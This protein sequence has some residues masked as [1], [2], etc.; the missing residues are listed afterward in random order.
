MF[1]HSIDMKQYHK[2]LVLADQSVENT[3]SKIDAYSKIY[4]GNKTPHLFSSIT[5][6]KNNEKHPQNILIRC[7]DNISFFNFHNL[8]MWFNKHS[9]IG[10]MLCSLNVSES[11]YCCPIDNLF[12][13]T[14]TGYFYD[15]S[16]LSIYIPESFTEYGNLI[17]SE[18]EQDILSLTALMHIY[19]TEYFFS[20]DSF[21][22]QKFNIQL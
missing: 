6:T 12:E 1:I 5:L 16:K 9:C 2:F 21:K 13:D 20:F 18:K 10:V 7:P 15:N 4:I 8:I 3:I 14:L 17:K 11:Y 22:S 19:G